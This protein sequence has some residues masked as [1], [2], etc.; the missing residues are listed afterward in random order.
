MVG[1]PTG[2]NRSI[3][4]VSSIRA[5]G[6]RPGLSAYASTK[7]ALN[8]LTRV[9]AYELAAHGIRVNA[10]SPGITATP[11]ALEQ[12]PEVFAERTKHVPMGRAGAPSDMA[13][14]ALYLASPASAFTTGTNLV[15]DGGESLW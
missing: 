11:L 9:A 12:N 8:Q 6:V 4:L 1:A 5:G 10:L 14:G 13:A 2:T 7:A 15:V 3:V